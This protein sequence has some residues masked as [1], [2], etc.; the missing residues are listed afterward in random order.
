[1]RAGDGSGPLPHGRLGPLLFPDPSGI[2]GDVIPWRRLA[3]D[4][5]RAELPPAE[6]WFHGERLGAV[7]CM[8][9]GTLGGVPLAIRSERQSAGPVRF[10]VSVA[11][12]QIVSRFDREC[13]WWSP[14]ATPERTPYTLEH[15]QIHFGLTEL[16]ARR[17]QRSLDEQRHL[18]EARATSAERAQ[19]RIRMQLEIELRGASEELRADHARFDAETS[20]RF[21]PI[22]QDR[23][24]AR[25]EKELGEPPPAS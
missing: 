21:D 5:F 17:L 16:A 7:A 22:A 8:F 4:D 2:S 11:R 1:M 13:S 19:E 15:E 12:L 9:V 14:E 18:L 3:V 10:H 6:L 20:G 23:W 24:R 25:V